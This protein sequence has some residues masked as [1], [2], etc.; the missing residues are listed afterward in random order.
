[1]GR[2][3]IVQLASSTTSGRVNN[4]LREPPPRYYIVRPVSNEE[5]SAIRNV[6]E[7][8]SIITVCH[9]ASVAQS[10]LLATYVSPNVMRCYPESLTRDL[11]VE[12]P[13]DDRGK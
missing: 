12:I 11:L 6:Y 4:F 3:G 7:S 9:A 1:M 10:D 5:R 8:L 13:M 2:G